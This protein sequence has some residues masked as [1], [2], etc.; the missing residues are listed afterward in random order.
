MKPM[1]S[2]TLSVIVSFAMAVGGAGIAAAQ[3]GTQPSQSA[4]AGASA[5]V[6]AGTGFANKAAVEPGT[7]FAAGT[8]VYVVSKVLNAPG[9]TVTHVWKLNGTKNWQAKLKVG[10]K[11]WTTSSRRQVKAGA[12]TV[13]VQAA[14]G[15][16]LGS[17]DF[18]AK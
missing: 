4:A 18:T 17:V 8:K 7:E 11:A 15:S 13:E 14:D 2:S 1:F 5:E 16:V 3:P 10:S 9:T 12:W 6:A